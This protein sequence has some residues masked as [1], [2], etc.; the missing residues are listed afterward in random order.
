MHYQRQMRFLGACGQARVRAARVA[1]VGLGAIGSVLAERLVRAGVGFMRLIDRDFVERENLHTQALYESE[2]AEA[3]LPKA[4]AAWRKL[5]LVNPQAALEA[6]VADLNPENIESLLGD[7]DL[8]LDATDNFETR[9]LINDFCVKA[10]IPWIYSAAVEG[11]GVTMTIIPHE[12]ACLRCLY[13]KPPQPGT[14]PTC[15][16]SGVINSIPGVIASVASAEALK[17][18]AGVGSPNAGVLYIDLWENAWQWFAVGRRDD[19]PACALRRFEYLEA[20]GGGAVTLCGRDAVQVRPARAGALDLEA[21]AARLRAVG[22]VFV[23][24]YLLRFRRGELQIVLF[25][26]GRAIITGTSDIARAR[27]WYSQYIGL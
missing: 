11:Y 16:T 20:G 13:Q 12:T 23:N 9:L 5:S 21:L 8:V 25:A 10:R 7:V 27:S 1:L 15:E 17:V 4:I 18:L 24:E 2:D 6:L 14:L 3:C 26:D 22:E 19:C